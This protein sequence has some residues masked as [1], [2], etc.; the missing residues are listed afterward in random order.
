MNGFP[1]YLIFKPPKGT[2]LWLGFLCKQCDSARP[3]AFAESEGGREMVISH[4]LCKRQ[5]ICTPLPK[6]RPLWVPN[7][8]AQKVG[9]DSELG[10]L[11]LGYS[12]KPSNTPATGKWVMQRLK[13]WWISPR[14]QLFIR[15]DLYTTEHK[16]SDGVQIQRYLKQYHPHL[17]LQILVLQPDDNAWDPLT[18]QTPT[19][20][21]PSPVIWLSLLYLNSL[22]RACKVFPSH[23]STLQAQVAHSFIPVS[24]VL[25]QWI[26]SPPC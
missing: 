6:H 1:D 16:G 25:P 8:R 15:V 17:V 18:I 20:R 24:N 7:F 14:Q 22:W 21:R 3:W 19:S 4:C 5:A 11:R 23:I 9:R 26:S 12:W 2:F 10:S 13:A